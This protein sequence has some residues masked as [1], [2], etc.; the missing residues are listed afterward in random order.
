MGES[1]YLARAVALA[2]KSLGGTRPNPAVGAV[3]VKNG[4][5]IGEGRHKKAGGDHAETAAIKDAFRR[6]AKTLQGA[7]I[8]VTLEPCSKAGRVGACTDA[9]A[10]SGIARVVY[11]VADPNPKNRGK[12]AR[13]LK[14]FGVVCE[15]ALALLKRVDGEEREKIKGSI[16]A[17]K[18]II[19]PFAKH[20]IERLPYVIVKLAMSLDGR[21]CDLKGN[22]KWISSARSRR[23]TGRMRADVDAIMVGGETVRRDNPSL[24]CRYG[25]NDSLIRVV[26][27]KSRDLPASSQIFTDDAADRTLVFSDPKEA[28]EKLGEMGIT[29]VLCEGGLEL[30]RSLHKKGLV[31]EWHTVLSP[32]VIGKENIAEAKRFSRGVCRMSDGALGDVH[33]KA[34]NGEVPFL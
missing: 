9:I 6:G 32:V 3:I 24:L 8:F 10:S 22:A 28:L 2:R 20:V 7:E 12:A 21:I 30:A 16:A 27:S 33:A 5:I 26:I 15:N 1:E 11:C 25:R 23:E 18:S 34:Y 17:A 4:K 29:S 14:Q 31:D 13:A 19:A